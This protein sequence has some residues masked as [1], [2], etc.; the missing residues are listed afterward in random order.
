MCLL[1]NN[2]RQSSTQHR[3]CADISQASIFGAISP[4]SG[5]SRQHTPKLKAISPAN[6]CSADVTSGRGFSY[7][8]KSSPQR[9]VTQC[10]YVSHALIF[11]RLISSFMLINRP[12]H[13]QQR[14][15]IRNR[16]TNDIPERAGQAKRKTLLSFMRTMFQQGKQYISDKQKHTQ[17]IS[18]TNIM[19]EIVILTFLRMLE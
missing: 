3:Q 8:G 19:H 1:P 6:K 10:A 17:N 2:T 15:T 5:L 11:A 13:S 14:I 16:Y 18:L 9:F 12:N 7:P 4:F